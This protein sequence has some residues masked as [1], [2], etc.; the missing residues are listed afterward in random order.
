MIVSSFFLVA[1]LRRRGGERQRAAF[2]RRFDRSQV[3]EIIER[4]VDDRRTSPDE[5]AHFRPGS[6]PVTTGSD[7][8]RRDVAMI[9]LL[10][11]AGFDTTSNLIVVPSWRCSIIPSK[12]LRLRGDR[13]HCSA[14]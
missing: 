12:R 7:E 6:K 1:A 11:L 13:N 9:F 10:M 4:M 8:R 3:D 14:V 2:A 5:R